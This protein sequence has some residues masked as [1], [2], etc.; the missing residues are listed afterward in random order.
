MNTN[1]IYRID[2]FSRYYLKITVTGYGDQYYLMV[3]NNGTAF[4]NPNSDIITDINNNTVYYDSNSPVTTYQKNGT[5]YNI[6]DSCTL[7]K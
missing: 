3:D 6:P 7:I 5:T 1:V 4:N 2:E